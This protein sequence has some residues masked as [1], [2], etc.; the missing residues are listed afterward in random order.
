MDNIAASTVKVTA[1]EPY[2][3]NKVRIS[4]ELVVDVHRLADISSS[5]LSVATKGIVAEKK[6]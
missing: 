1:V 2:G 3:D 4:M 5:M 6:R